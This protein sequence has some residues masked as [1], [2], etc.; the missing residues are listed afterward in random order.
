VRIKLNVFF[1]L[2]LFASYFVGWLQQSL[3][4]FMSVLIHELGHVLAA[5]KLKINVYEVELLP[6]GEL[7]G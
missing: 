5:K 2:F 1:I 7:P 4:L 3:I 6:Y